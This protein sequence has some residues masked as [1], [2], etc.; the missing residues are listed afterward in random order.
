MPVDFPVTVE[1]VID[2]KGTLELL[3]APELPPGPVRVR[4]EALHGA[5]L[6]EWAEPGG[7]IV[8]PFDL[9]LPEPGVPVTASKIAE[10]LPVPFELSESDFAPE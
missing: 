6:S 10:F 2:A 7:M 9:P 4:L 3:H 5:A 1:G 8:A